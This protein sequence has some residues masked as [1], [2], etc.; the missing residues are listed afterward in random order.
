MS[1][2]PTLRLVSD[3][4]ERGLSARR[5]N[6]VLLVLKMILKTA[7]RRKWLREDPLAEVKLLHKPPTEVDPMGPEEIDAFLA[8][9]PAWWRPYFTVAFWTGARPLDRSAS[10]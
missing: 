7:R 9:C 1:E 4:Q 5:I 2:G 6:L 10:Q 8:A 3:L